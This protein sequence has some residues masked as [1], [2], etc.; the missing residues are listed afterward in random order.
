MEYRL[1]QYFWTKYASPDSIAL[2]A[3]SGITFKSWGKQSEELSLS[4]TKGHIV[5]PVLYCATQ[6]EG[7]YI[8]DLLCAAY[9]VVSGY[10]TYSPDSV[11]CE[12]RSE[13]EKQKD[14]FHQVHSAPSYVNEVYWHFAP[15]LL[16]AVYN[17]QHYKNAICRF[18]SAQEILP[19]HYTEL[20]PY[21][22][23][24]RERYLLSEQLRISNTIT[25]CYSIIEELGF[26]TEGMRLFEAENAEWNPN[27]LKRISD[28][29]K[30]H[31]IDP[32]SK[33][34]MWLSRSAPS[35]SDE[36]K[37]I[38]RTHLCEH[39][40]GD[41]VNDFMISF[42]EGILELKRLR[43]KIGAHDLGD[44]VLKLSLYDAENAFS[45]TRLLILS[46][47]KINVLEALPPYDEE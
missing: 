42:S 5:E 47:F 6:E 45:L 21:E 10:I 3:T 33:T 24:F 43:N 34:V 35:A 4:V 29:L 20:H 40:D 36:N 25:A 2:S 22:D 30:S 13:D 46:F 12:I 38:D 31:G 17:N 44:R 18:H 32:L 14:P 41:R 1:H 7:E 16:S 26:K 9:T 23:A 19:L 27:V 8:A 39:S 28:L 37:A 15:K 11:L